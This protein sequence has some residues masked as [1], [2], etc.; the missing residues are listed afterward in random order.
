MKK[1]WILNSVCFIVAAVAV[2]L[3]LNKG[4]E[5]NNMGLDKNNMDVA[6]VAGDDFYGFATGGLAAR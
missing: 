5:M 3:M 1:R 2:I 4:R 6:I